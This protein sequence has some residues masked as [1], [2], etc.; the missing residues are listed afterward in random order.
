VI[1]QDDGVSLVVAG[2]TVARVADLTDLRARQLTLQEWG[3]D[4]RILV[5]F[6]VD[7]D[8]EEDDYFE[9]LRNL[10]V[11]SARL[12]NDLDTDAVLTINLERA[13]MRRVEGRVILYDW[14]PDWNDPDA[15]AALPTGYV[16][17]RDG[18][19]SAAAQ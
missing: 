16:H 7:R 15:L 1:G 5:A 13:L 11:A 2:P 10:S 9:A 12:A 14:W 6:R 19:A 8:A 18:D 17:V 3:V 4:S